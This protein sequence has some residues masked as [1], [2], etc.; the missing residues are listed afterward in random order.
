M[1][2][3][4]PIDIAEFRVKGGKKIDLADWPTQVHALYDS[5]SDYQE[6][7]D[8]IN[9]KVIQAETRLKD[10]KARQE[11]SEGKIRTLGYEP[12]TAKESLEALDKT[13]SELEKTIE[14]NLSRIEEIAAAMEV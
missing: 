3:H 12:E 9:R 5:K 2:K 11:E 7:L 10:I 13:I 14:S 4:K 8:A 6:R 1:S